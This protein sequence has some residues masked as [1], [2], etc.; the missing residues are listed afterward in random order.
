[1]YIRFLEKIPCKRYIAVA[2]RRFNC[3]HLIYLL[4]YK[5]SFPNQGF[6]TGHL[7]LDAHAGDGAN[8]NRKTEFRRKETEREKREKSKKNKKEKEK[9][10]SR[11]KMIK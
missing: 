10:F 4:F 3:L 8:N 9:T 5:F 11:K 2:G 7:T 1:L 6:S